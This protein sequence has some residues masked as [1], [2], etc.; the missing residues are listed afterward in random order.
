MSGKKHIGRHNIFDVNE[1]ARLVAIA[2]DRDGQIFHRAINEDRHGGGI[3]TL[4]ILARPKNIEVAQ[5]GSRQAAF[6]C[7][8][9]AIELPVELGAG[10]GAF[11]LGQHG[12]QLGDHRIVAVN[13]GGGAQRQL[14]HAGPGR[15]FEHDESAGGVDFIALDGL[16]HGFRHADHGREMKNVIHSLHRLTHRLPIQ[17]RGGDKLMLKGGEIGFET[18]AQIIEHAHLGPALKMF[19]DVAANK[20]GSAGDENFHK[21]EILAGATGTGHSTKVR[22]MLPFRMEHRK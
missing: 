18:G 14:F 11:R 17:N 15:L 20:P 21:L 2:V 1:I 7:K 16:G 4:G 8:H 9:R 13:G 19:D 3:L 10:I 22:W 6:V 12:L 5:A